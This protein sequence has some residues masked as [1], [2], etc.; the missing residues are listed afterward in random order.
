MLKQFVKS[1]VQPFGVDLIKYP[2]LSALAGQLKDLFRRNKINLVLDVGACDGGFARFLRG[3]VEY[4]GRIVSF[5]PTKSTFEKLCLSM[6]GD[7]EW[8]GLN[9]GVSDED[10]GGALNTYGDRYDFNSILNLRENDARSYNVD[11][12]QVH[13]EPIALRSI[14]SVWNEATKGISEPV[15]Y[16]KT[17]TQGHDPAVIRG[18]IPC[19]KYIVGLQS[20]IPAIQIYEGM[21]PM[22]D[23]LK[24]LASLSFI[25]IGFHPVNHPEQYD[26]MTPEFDVVFRKT[27]AKDFASP[28]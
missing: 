11:L 7:S 19:L 10:G 15:V 26:G 27:L 9:V 1:C 18:A 12:S 2:P 22:H 25:P 6:K 21:Q 28:K 24:A 4:Q 23:T 16:L 8:V 3:P 13:I 17:D 5:E 14:A 20:E